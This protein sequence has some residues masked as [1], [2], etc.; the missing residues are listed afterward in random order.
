MEDTAVEPLAFE[1]P[2][3]ENYW[4]S[5]TWSQELP[6]SVTMSTS[7]FPLVNRT[8]LEPEEMEE[9]SHYVVGFC[10]LTTGVIRVSSRKH[11]RQ[12]EEHLTEEDS[13]WGRALFWGR[14]SKLHPIKRTR[15]SLSKMRLQSADPLLRDLEAML[16]EEDE[17][18]FLH[19][20]TQY[21]Y[22]L[23]KQLVKDSYTHYIGS[24]P[25]PTIAPD[26]DGGA[27]VEW[28]SADGSV[29]RL[30]IRASQNG[31]HYI[32]SENLDRSH[33]DYVVSGLAIAQQL[34]SI[35]TD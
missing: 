33:V 34:R 26:G 29:V 5:K 9:T 16:K 35:F 12:A 28:R 6:D 17:P 4:L 20:P 3:S 10:D 13:S 32:Y 22:D 7:R 23:T 25:V 15:V 24:A 14:A 30:I 11:K 8:L 31:K 19:R 18:D 21:S 1:R 27:T 2:L